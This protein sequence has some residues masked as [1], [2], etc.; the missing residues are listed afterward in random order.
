M[1][2][3]GQILEGILIYRDEPK[4]PQLNPVAVV[5]SGDV[6]PFDAKFVVLA[7]VVEVEFQGLALLSLV[8]FCLFCLWFLQVLRALA[9]DSSSL[10]EK[11][12][13]EQGYPYSLLEI[14]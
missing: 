3:V 10:E 4:L 5:L 9:E 11:A 1:E 7:F 14:V 6:V 13:V 2:L 12:A 8:A